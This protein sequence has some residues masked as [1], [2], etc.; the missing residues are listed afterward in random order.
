[1]ALQFLVAST[2]SHFSAFFFAV[3][4]AACKQKLRVAVN[5]KMGIEP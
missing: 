1:M 2:T 3:Q 4:L 5:D